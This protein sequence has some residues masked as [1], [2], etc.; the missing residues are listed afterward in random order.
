MP[1]RREAFGVSAVEASASGIPV[2]AFNVGGIPEIVVDGK[3]GFLVD[4]V[5]IEK[6]G[7]ALVCMA[8]NDKLR[9]DMGLKS[10]IRAEELFDWND[11]IISMVKIYEQMNS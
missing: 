4:P 3:T 7:D 11:S 8:E 9:L 2:V 5:S 10:R 6:F 1:S